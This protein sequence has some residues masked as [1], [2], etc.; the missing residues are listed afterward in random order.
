MSMLS[1]KRQAIIFL[2]CSMIGAFAYAHPAVKYK[3]MNQVFTNSNTFKFDIYIENT[4]SVD[5]N[6]IYT[7]TY[8]NY[9]SSIL[10]GGT[11]SC[12]YVEGSSELPENHT[13]LFVC[14]TKKDGRIGLYYGAPP[15]KVSEITIEPGK[16]IKLA[17]LEFSTS[18]KSFKKKQMGLVWRE[19]SGSNPRTKFFFKEQGRT[20]ELVDGN[21]FTFFV[22]PES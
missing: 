7:Q 19:N 22:E 2:I 13:N 3:V 18:A 4:G 5:I 8:L 16:S 21:N 17:T 12:K 14:S 1:I 15:L 11:A 20:K 10:N 6:Y 9:T